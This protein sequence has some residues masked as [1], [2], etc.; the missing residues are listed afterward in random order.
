MRTKK[1]HQNLR[2]ALKL[3]LIKIQ[4]KKRY[5]TTWNNM[6]N[7]KVLSFQ[8]T[9]FRCEATN[10]YV[11]YNIRSESWVKNGGGQFEPFRYDRKN[12]AVFTSY[13]RSSDLSSRNDDDIKT[14][15]RIKG[16]SSKS[17]WWNWWNGKWENFYTFYLTFIIL[18]HYISGFDSVSI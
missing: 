4:S 10:F 5:E 15:Q 2:S 7:E 17:H 11:S 14:H 3:K 16:N 12:L 1:F 18:L 6:E 8:I 13:N 9:C